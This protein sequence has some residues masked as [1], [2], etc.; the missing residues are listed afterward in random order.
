MH[1]LHKLALKQVTKEK[2]LTLDVGCG[3]K[4]YH[5]YYNGTTVSIDIKEKPTVFAAGEYLPFKD[6]TFDV[7][8]MLS[9]LEYVDNPTTLVYEARR[10]LKDNGLLLIISQN[11][12]ATDRY[13]KNIF[14]S[15]DLQRLVR[16]CG[17]NIAYQY[18]HLILVGL[19]YDFTSVYAYMVAQK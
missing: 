18:W 7:V 6:S 9:V 1:W 19:Y 16:I 3:R 12:N 15:Y 11:A 8:T 2:T 10:I 5:P 13:R 17:F 4:A 14:S